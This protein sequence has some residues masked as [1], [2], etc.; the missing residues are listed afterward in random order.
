MLKEKELTAYSIDL[1]NWLRQFEFDNPIQPLRAC[2]LA[3][4]MR[5]DEMMQQ[6]QRIL[7]NL[8]H[9]GSAQSE[10]VK[11]LK[12]TRHYIGRLAHH[13]RSAFELMSDGARLTELLST[14]QVERVPQPECVPALPPDNQTKLQR[15]LNR[16]M[17]AHEK[18]RRARIDASMD[19]LQSGITD[20][21]IVELFK[22]PS[23]KPR[24][25]SEVQVAEH[26]YKNGLRF[27][28]GD[29]FVATSKMSCVCCKLYFRHHPSH[30]EEPETH[31]KLYD[32]WG[33][34]NLPGG[35]EHPDFGAQRD[36]M[37]KIIQDLREETLDRLLGLANSWSFH[38]D[39]ISGIT[40]LDNMSNL[41]DG[42][43]SAS[44]SGWASDPGHETPVEDDSQAETLVIPETSEDED[45]DT[46]GGA[47]L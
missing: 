26:F 31:G 20:D 38:P 17:G 6:L 45:E 19:K 27:A 37:N 11:H 46:T 32:S 44:D 18:E 9:D 28:Y 12:R 5:H 40:P 7:G 36:L 23:F 8:S 16:M 4:N 22:R 34:I 33:P 13:V 1:I 43:N 42:D 24:V 35:R 39:S 41:E 30:L 25:H 3:Y 2:I 21:K 29:K 47:P 15:I 14:S 10:P